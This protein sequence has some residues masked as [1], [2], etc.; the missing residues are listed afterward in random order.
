MVNNEEFKLSRF[1]SKENFSSFTWCMGFVV[2]ITEVLKMFFVGVDPRILVVICSA[3]V[4][5]ARAYL[6]GKEGNKN[7]KEEILIS[8]CDVFPISICAMGCYDVL[9]KLFEKSLEMII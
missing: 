9:L 1:I 3:F 4:S 7:L 6:L 2:S 5:F 8:F